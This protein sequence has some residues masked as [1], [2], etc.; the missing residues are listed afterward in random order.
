MAVRIGS[1]VSDGNY[2]GLWKEI[3]GFLTFIAF[4]LFVRHATILHLD[5]EER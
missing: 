1:A 3:L 2:E 4:T 5:A